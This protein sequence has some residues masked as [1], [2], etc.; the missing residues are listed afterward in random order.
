MKTYILKYAVYNSIDFPAG[1]TVKIT[2]DYWEGNDNLNTGFTVVKGKLKG[3]KGSVANGLNVY[4]LDDTDKNRKMFAQFQSAIK[5]LE[6]DI[7]LLNKKW[8][9]VPAA[10]L[11]IK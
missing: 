4:L 3:V 10:N 5:K 9:D 8:D 6:G 11:T 1:T 7:N 2:D